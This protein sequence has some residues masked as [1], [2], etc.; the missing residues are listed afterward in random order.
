SLSEFMQNLK[1]Y[2]TGKVHSEGGLDSIQAEVPMDTIIKHMEN[3]ENRIYAFSQGVN[4][5]TD[6]FGNSPSGIALKFLYSLLDL[7]ASTLERKFRPS[8]Q[9]LIWFLCE[10][11]SMSGKGEYDYK[12]GDYTFKRSMMVNDLETVT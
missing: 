11:L 7:K 10:Y 9:Q 6:K 1:Y 2:K 12:A 4:I 3:L 5:G 8:I